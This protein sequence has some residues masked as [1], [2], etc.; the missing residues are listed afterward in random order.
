MRGHRVY[1]RFVCVQGAACGVEARNAAVKSMSDR[2][3]AMSA[4][5]A[6]LGDGAMEVNVGRAEAGKGDRGK[7][8][9]LAAKGGEMMGL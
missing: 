8:T 5:T 1:K 3:G 9:A 2:C 6:K 7:T 4:G